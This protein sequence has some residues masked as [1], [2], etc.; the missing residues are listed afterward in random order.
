MARK[1]ERDHTFAALD[2][3]RERALRI[4]DFQIEAHRY[5]ILSDIHKGDRR[6]G[7]DDF[8]RNEMVYCYALQ[9]YLDHGYRLILNGDVEEGWEANYTSIIEA[10]ESSAFAL[11]REFARQGE[12]CYIRTYGNHDIEWSDPEQVQQHL[13]PVLG[14]I[15]VYPAVLLGDRIFVVHGHQGDPYS[16]QSAGFSRFVVRHFW[17]WL[18]GHLGLQSDR[19]AENNFI[20]R[21]RDRYLYEWAKANG[22]LLIAGHTHRAM[23]RSFSKTYQ[24]KLIRDELIERLNSTADPYMRYLLPAAIDRI[25]MIIWSSTE[26]L[27]ADKEISRLGEHPAPCYFN[28]GCC[29]HSNGMT[30]M[31]IDEGEI[32]LVKWEVSDTYCAFPGEA[33]RRADVFANIERR[34]YQTGD[35]SDILSHL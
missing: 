35:L 13:A 10:Y 24:L 25:D 20:R 8:E 9:Y 3:A 6:K 7:S 21:N 15:Q 27:D 33:R 18:Q 32:R 28:D 34:I 12:S 30:G 1:S 4:P 5:A 19:A 26:E 14:P 16:D 29:V 22:L 31:E 17:R 2:A 11:E 23:F